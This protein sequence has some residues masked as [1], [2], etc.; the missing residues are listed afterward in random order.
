MSALFTTNQA[1]KPAG[2]LDRARR[3]IDIGTVFLSRRVGYVSLQ[4]GRPFLITPNLPMTVYVVLRIS[5]Q[6]SLDTWTPEEAVGFSKKEP[7]L[8][9][10]SVK[11]SGSLLPLIIPTRTVETI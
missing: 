11:T 6:L 7:E 9:L 10:L 2:T 4:L 1:T 8:I 3:D 5:S